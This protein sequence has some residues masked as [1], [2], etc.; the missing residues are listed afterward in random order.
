MA[1]SKAVIA[2]ELVCDREN[3]KDVM[4]GTDVVWLKKGDI[5]NVPESAW[6]K[7]ALHPDV[8]RLAHPVT[9]AEMDRQAALKSAAEATEKLDKAIDTANPDATYKPKRVTAEQIADIPDDKLREEAEKRGYK[10]HAMLSS[11][12]LRVRFLAAQETDANLS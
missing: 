6:P 9:A 5:K 10:L 3:H 2:V 1:D 8:Y 11:A 7:M 4:Y 12:N